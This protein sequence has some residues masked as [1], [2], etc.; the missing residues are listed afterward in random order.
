MEE[1]DWKRSDRKKNMEESDW[2][3]MAGRIMYGRVG[4]EENDRKRNMEEC[5]WKRNDRTG[6]WG[7]HLQM[8]LKV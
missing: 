3:E 4:L 7:G 8:D 6:R 5:D 2:K 1:C